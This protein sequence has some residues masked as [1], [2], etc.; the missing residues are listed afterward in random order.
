MKMVMPMSDVIIS[1]EREAKAIRKDIETARKIIEDGLIRYKKKMLHA[2]S[3][4]QTEDLSMFEEI[5]GYE[6]KQDIQE[7]YGYG[8]M[9]NAKYGRLN[10]LWD[11]REEFVTA[12]GQFDSR[13][14]QILS[15]A[16]NQCNN[17]FEEALYEFEEKQRKERN[18][19]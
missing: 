14:T 16:M 7:D 8:E 10:D 4:K 2:R 9:S 3:K 13:V 5:A 19:L 17:L 12:Q 15:R 18:G 6:S 11:A 1:T